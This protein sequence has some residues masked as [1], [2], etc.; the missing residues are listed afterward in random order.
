MKKSILAIALVFVFTASG[1]LAEDL[2]E[3]SPDLE[4]AAQVRNYYVDWLSSFP[5]VADV[6][7]GKTSQGQPAVIVTLNEV[8]PQARHIPH[9]LN[10]IPVEVVQPKGSVPMQAD[11][12]ANVAQSEEAAP[13]NNDDDLVKPNPADTAPAA[14]GGAPGGGSGSSLPAPLCNF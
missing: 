6:G 14:P 10:G 12:D 8:T 4:A 1:A 11:D 2:G 5:G 7:V 9:Q 13:S 3:L